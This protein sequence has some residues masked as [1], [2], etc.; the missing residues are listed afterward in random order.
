MLSLLVLMLD[1]EPQDILGGLYMELGLS[2]SN[3]GQF[4]IPPAI[5]ELMAML[6]FGDAIDKL[7]SFITL[8]EP[9]CGSGGMVLDFAKQVINKGHNPLNT[10]LGAVL[11]Y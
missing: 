10:L 7:D 5:S 9:A 4:F 6:S 8:S 2:N 3:N 11:G 1:V